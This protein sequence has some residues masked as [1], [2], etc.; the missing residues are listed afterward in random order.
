[1]K[2]FWNLFDVFLPMENALLLH[3]FVKTNKDR[4]E[5]GGIGPT[6]SLS[7]FEIFICILKF[8]KL[9]KVIFLLHPIRPNI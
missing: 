5:I 3:K 9:G 4:K 8:K 6:C 2:Y 7:L 1:V